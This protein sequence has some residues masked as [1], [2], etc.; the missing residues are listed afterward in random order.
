[1]KQ[2]SHKRGRRCAICQ[3]H[4]QDK[5][6]VKYVAFGSSRFLHTSA[7]RCAENLNLLEK[8]KVDGNGNGEDD[9]WVSWLQH[10]PKDYAETMNDATCN[11]SLNWL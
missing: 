1:M 3:R 6:Y 5:D 4:L 7:K 2:R 8:R 11:L 10:A 9:D